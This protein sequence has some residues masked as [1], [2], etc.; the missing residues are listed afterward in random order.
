MTGIRTHTLY[1]IKKMLH[2]IDINYWAA[3]I[4]IR[5][6][7]H[8]STIHLRDNNQKVTA[9]IQIRNRTHTSTI[10]LRGNNQ[11]VTATIQI[12]NRT[13]TSTIHFRNRTHTST[14]HFRN[15]THTSTIHL[16]DNNQTVY[17][18][19]GLMNLFRD[20]MAA[21]VL[22]GIRTQTSTIPMVRKNLKFARDWG[23]WARSNAANS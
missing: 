15:R 8:T 9:T 21:I 12:R 14:I 22:S 7:T 19:L 6:P 11:T 1:S 18:R 2:G 5:N 10:H 20:K 23:Y 17:T 3:T 13:H 4:Q 16:R